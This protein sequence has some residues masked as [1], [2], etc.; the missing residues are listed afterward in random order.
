MEH[1]LIIETGQHFLPPAGS[2]CLL[3][4]DEDFNNFWIM[5]SWQICCMR[6]YM[7]ADAALCDVEPVVLNGLPITHRPRSCLQPQISE[8]L[9]ATATAGR[10]DCVRTTYTIGS[11]LPN[12]PT[13]SWKAL[14]PLLPPWF[15]A[16]HS[17]LSL[18]DT[19]PLQTPSISPTPS[20]SH[21]SQVFKEWGWSREQTSTAPPWGKPNFW[22]APSIFFHRGVRLLSRVRKGVY[23]PFNAI[24]NK[25]VS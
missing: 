14:S 7:M 24:P 3:V 5:V 10:Q 12:L 18:H 8:H 11:L 15:A 17:P 4:S 23:K 16:L 19:T 13:L 20:Q 2:L 21:Q 9:I 22:V 6:P 1:N 25:L